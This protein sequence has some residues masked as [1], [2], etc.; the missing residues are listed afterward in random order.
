MPPT[1]SSPGTRFSSVHT[2]LLHSASPCQD[3]APCPAPSSAKFLLKCPW[4]SLLHIPGRSVVPLSPP[5]PLPP[6]Q[7]LPYSCQVSTTT[8]FP[9]RQA[10]DSRCRDTALHTSAESW[11]QARA[12]HR[13]GCT[14]W[15]VAGWA[16]GW[17]D[18]QTDICHQQ[19]RLLWAQRS[20]SRVTGLSST[21]QL[22][23]REGQAAFHIHN[24]FQQVI[25]HPKL[26]KMNFCF[27]LQA[28]M[29]AHCA[30]SV[31][32]SNDRWREK[33]LQTGAHL[34]AP[35]ARLST[36]SCPVC[37]LPAPPETS[38]RPGHSCPRD[39]PTKA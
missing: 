13:P 1:S 9:P 35:T 3:P 36:D 18:R 8:P 4:G 22:Q 14:L 28:P 5:I 26:Y 24:E 25:S 12:P 10:G 6:S 2:A 32:D 11:G 30:P 17:T 39:P 34:C 23:F 16:G 20:V 15:K 31:L 37:L 21:T 19:I 38:S 27:H 33:Q 29:G 7:H